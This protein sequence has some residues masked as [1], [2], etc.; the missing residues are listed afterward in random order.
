MIFKRRS[1][2]KECKK[3]GEGERCLDIDPNCVPCTALYFQLFKKSF[4]VL[5]F[6]IF[7]SPFY[8]RLVC[9]IYHIFLRILCKSSDCTMSSTEKEECST[10]QSFTAQPR[11]HV[12]SWCENSETS[13]CRELNEPSHSIIHRSITISWHEQGSKNIFTLCK[14]TWEIYSYER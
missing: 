6:I 4:D 13:L 1:G 3:S 11:T 5:V 12:R 14:H 9:F 2:R 10:N 7:F 8:P